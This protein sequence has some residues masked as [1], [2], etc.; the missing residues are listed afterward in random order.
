[1]IASFG[2]ANDG[3]LYLVAI[4]GELY[5][6]GEPGPD[7]DGDGRQDAIDNCLTVANPDQADTDGDGVGMS[8]T[9]A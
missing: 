5:Q 3:E 7:T 9:T 1:M 8:A 2:E 6:L 4:T